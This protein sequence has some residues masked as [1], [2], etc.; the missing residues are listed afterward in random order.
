MCENTIA[1]FPNKTNRNEPKDMNPI[2]LKHY[3]ES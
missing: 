2:H 3:F 1:Q